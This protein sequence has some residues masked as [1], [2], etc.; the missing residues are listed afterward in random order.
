[1]ILQWLSASTL[2]SPAAANRRNPIVSECSW[3]MAS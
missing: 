1:M 2:N 3:S